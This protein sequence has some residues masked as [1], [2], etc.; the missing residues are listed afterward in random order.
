[1]QEL[2]EDKII[3]ISKENLPLIENIFYKIE[4]EYKGNR[5]NV[6][7]LIKLYISELICLLHRYRL[8]KN[9]DEQNIDKLMQ[10]ITQYINDNFE[11]EITLTD[12]SKIFGISESHLS[13][14]F[15]LSTGTCINEYINYVRITNAEWLLKTKK[16]PI[17][18]VAIRCGFNDSSYFAHVF[19]KLKGIT[20]YKFSKRE[21]LKKE[22]VSSY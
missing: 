11:K 4:S 14:R 9:V 5:K 10:E 12:L 20:P 8:L 7:I 17:T 6:D 18:E 16:L 3:H 21:F 22:N 1:M 15:K 19:K 13:R 2:F